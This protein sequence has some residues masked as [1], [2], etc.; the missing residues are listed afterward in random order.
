MNPSNPLQTE[1]E[2]GNDYYFAASAVSPNAHHQDTGVCLFTIDHV[3]KP[4]SN[5]T[6]TLED[7]YFEKP[8]SQQPFLDCLTQAWHRE[9]RLFEKQLEEYGNEAHLTT[10]LAAIQY[11][12]TLPDTNPQNE[13][14][15]PPD[16]EGDDDDS[17]L[18]LQNPTK[19]PI[20]SKDFLRALPQ[21]PTIHWASQMCNDPKLCFCPC[22]IY[23]KP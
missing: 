23:S 10:V 6:H 21:C 16:F 9:I 11:S 22:S 13:D 17:Y 14:D 7:Q 2:I 1:P 3:A 5:A 8:E 19:A 20:I 12:E 15:Y 4:L 18:L